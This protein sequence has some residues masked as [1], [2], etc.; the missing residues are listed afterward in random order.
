MHPGKIAGDDG[1]ERVE[2]LRHDDL[3]ERILEPSERR[4]AGHGVPVASGGTSRV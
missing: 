1:A 4:Q 3:A 2:S